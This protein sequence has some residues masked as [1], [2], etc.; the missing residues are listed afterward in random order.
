MRDVDVVGVGAGLAGL[1]AARSLPAAGR[2]R[3]LQL[4]FSSNPGQSLVQEDCTVVVRKFG[5]E[6][7]IE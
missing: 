7:E 4:G 1:S 3:R 5:T 2:N 6:W